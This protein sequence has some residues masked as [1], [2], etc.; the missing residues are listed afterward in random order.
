MGW[1]GHNR[2]FPKSASY[3]LLNKPY[4]GS[5]GAEY[6]ITPKLSTLQ[7]ESVMRISRTCIATILAAALIAATS[8]IAQE[9]APPRQDPCNAM[10][11]FNQFDFWVGEWTVATADGTRAGRNIIRK[12]K[13]GCLL[14][15]HWT[16]FSKAKR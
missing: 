10:A 11:Q 12:E 14:R 5:A 8:L 13:G 9:P 7:P 16:S 4:L 3:P 6:L 15:E 1:H 2:L